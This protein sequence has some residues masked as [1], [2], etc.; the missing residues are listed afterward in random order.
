MA[1]TNYDAS[2]I[3]ILKGLE[4]VR[5]RPG[6]YI[7]STDTNGL[8]H[9]VWEIL[10]N[11]MDEAL[12]GYGK[13]IKITI[14]KDN[15]ICVEDEGRGIPVGM[16]ASGVPTIQVIYT[17]LHAGAKFS[18]D[19]GYKTAGG[20]HGVG[21][22][23]VNALSE[24]MEVT[25][26]YQGKT[27]RMRFEK[28]GS[29]VG[30]LET[31][32]TT[33][34]TG[35][36]VRFLADKK[37]FDR[38]DYHYSV[39]LERVRESAFLLSGMKI[40]LKDE[41]SGA[42]EEFCYENGLE[43]F[44]NY[45]H[46]DKTPISPIVMFNGGNDKISAQIAFQYIDSYQENT[47]S[48]V[49]YVRTAD[50]GSHEVGYKSAFT[51]VF[52]EYARKNGFLKE[53]DSN[54]EGSDVREGL[55]S[56][57][58]VTVTEDLLQFE[59]QTKG[60]LGTP[61][62][63]VVLD[64]IIS[65]KLTF[66]LEENKEL[67]NALVKKMIKASQVREA[68]RK[69]RDEARAGKKNNNKAEKIISGKLA[70]AQSKDSRKKELFIVEGDS[71]GGSAKQG[72]DSKY[73]AILPLRGKVLNTEKASLAE[74]MKNEELATL[75]YTIGAGIGEEFDVEASNYNKVIIMTDADTDGAHIQVLLLTFFFR[76]MRPL[77]EAGMVYVALPPL[78]KA[79]KGKETWYAFNDEELDDIR[80]QHGKVE[81]QRY[82]GLGEMN[83]D[84]LWETTMN[85]EN[86]TL[87][88]VRI[89]D[90]M[91]TDKKFNI[92]M[93]NDADVR[94]HWI[95]DYVTFTLEDSFVLEGQ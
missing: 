65:D 33:A 39:I 75:I 44:I 29:K 1:K 76:Y 60:K 13:C 69:A 92:L 79:S 93:G 17:Q 70:P 66:Y 57:I 2:S 36:K 26:N 53:K 82:K 32:G 14:E 78:Y 48:F 72:R 43:S 64:N 3:T 7:G 94:R 4:P 81:I 28:G 67:A 68:A 61:E 34:K 10:D 45:L 62:A 83:A 89:D 58:S 77:I 51:K 21:A 15:V 8:H 5:K 50:G 91:A 11:S 85:P 16:H 31:L 84:Q 55:T 6:M 19:A 20:L 95:E 71:A 80:Q 52:N 46:E 9:L 12:N 25:T 42:S 49:N 87:V 56:V 86:R 27:Y 18:S 22:S 35:T 24:W 23:V 59:G 90:N 73:Q 38:I 47:Y 88:R 30:K 63:R 40:I 37:I 41:R 54:L 74:V